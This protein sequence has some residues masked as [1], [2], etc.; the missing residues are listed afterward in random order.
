MYINDIF[1]F[2]SPHGSTRYHHQNRPKEIDGPGLRSPNGRQSPL[3]LRR[4][5]PMELPI[6]QAY[7]L[8]KDVEWFS[9][10]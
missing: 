7:Q 1:P 2:S 9:C 6:C 4:A 8:E 3:P 10:G 5:D